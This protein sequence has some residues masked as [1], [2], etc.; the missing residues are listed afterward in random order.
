[1]TEKA[2][3]KPEATRI[4]FFDAERHRRVQKYRT[5]A[6]IWTDFGDRFGGLILRIR[7]MNSRHVQIAREALEQEIRRQTSNDSNPLTPEEERRLSAIVVKMAITGARGA[8]NNAEAV[9]AAKR[10]K[11]KTVDVDGATVVVFSGTEDADTV[12]EAIVPLVQDSE[13]FTLAIVKASNRLRQVTDA[14]VDA[15]GEGFVFGQHVALESED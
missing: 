8:T 13:D 4:T 10:H 1:M 6:G 9:A 7:Q 11:L 5:G 3:T 12:R 14:E 2:S 15:V